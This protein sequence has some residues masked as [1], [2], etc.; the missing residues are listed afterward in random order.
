MESNNIKFIYRNVTDEEYKR[1]MNAF[2]EYGA[3]FGNSEE[4]QERYGFVAMDNERLIGYSSGLCTKINN[5]YS[6]YFYLSDLLVEK[7]YRKL[8][9]GKKLLELLEQEMKKLGIKYIWTWTTYEAPEFYLKQGYKTFT[10]F[11]N[12][13][14][15][16]HSKYGFIK[17]L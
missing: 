15:S 4:I 1:A 11:E 17:E 13:L 12:F 9:Y 8:G 7:E 14:P 6:E 3:E 2:N 5:K 10:V 16:G